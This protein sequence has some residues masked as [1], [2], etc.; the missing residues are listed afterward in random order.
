M[1]INEL[2][3]G[4]GFIDQNNNLCK[5]HDNKPNECRLYPYDKRKLDEKEHKRFLETCK[6]LK[7]IK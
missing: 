1:L 2:Q 7:R 4:C 6:G 5:N 3:G